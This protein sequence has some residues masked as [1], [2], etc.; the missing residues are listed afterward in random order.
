MHSSR[1]RTA[2]TLLY[3]G[4]PDRDPPLDRDPPS[5]QRP[6]GQRPTPY[7]DPSLDRDPPVDR[8]TPVKTK[9]SQTSFGVLEKGCKS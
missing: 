6:P 1:M 3:E 9:P 2:R 4:L 8:Q 5:G 7:R